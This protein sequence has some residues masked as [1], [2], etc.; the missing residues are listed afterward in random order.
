MAQA[1]FPQGEKNPPIY[2][3]NEEQERQNQAFIVVDQQPPTR[4]ERFPYSLPIKWIFAFSIA[5]CVIASI[6]IIFGIVNLSMLILHF[7]TE[8]AFPIWC[9]SIV[10]I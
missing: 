6:M 5:E 3:H 10:S 4:S 7:T 2:V 8:I 9:G 1:S